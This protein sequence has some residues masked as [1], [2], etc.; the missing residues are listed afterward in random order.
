MGKT[1]IRGFSAGFN[2]RHWQQSFSYNR[3]KGYYLENTAAYRTNWTPDQPYIQFP[4]LVFK[5]YQGT[6][7]YNFNPGFQ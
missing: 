2:F 4:D 6:T 3:T 7:A 1:R 5:Q